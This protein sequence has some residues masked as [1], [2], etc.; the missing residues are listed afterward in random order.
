MQLFKLK[1]TISKF[2]DFASFAKEYNLNQSDLV[3][4][5]EFLYTPFMKSLNLPCLFIMQE[6]YGLGEPSDEMLNNILKDVKGKKYDRVI[7]I[8][9]GTVIDISKIFALKGIDNVTDAFERKVPIVK[10]KKLIIIPTTCGTGSE[11]TNISIAEIKSKK[12][13]MG[14]ADDAILADGDKLLLE[15]NSDITYKG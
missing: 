3:I 9:G 8:G 1:T 12:T 10:E 14:L 13:K 15:L 4:T 2:K 5:N 11:V 7:A 6:Q